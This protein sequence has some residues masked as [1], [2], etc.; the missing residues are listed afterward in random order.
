MDLCAHLLNN[1]GTFNE[2]FGNNGIVIS[3][4]TSH[5]FTLETMTVLEDGKIVIGGYYDDHIALMKFNEDGSFDTSFGENGMYTYVFT[6]DVENYF[7]FF[8]KP[9]QRS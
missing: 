9:N 1:D 5:Q 8:R 6:E 2:S 4:N 3:N 7:C